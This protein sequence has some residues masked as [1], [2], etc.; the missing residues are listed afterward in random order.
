MWD[1][2]DWVDFY[3]STWNQ[4]APLKVALWAI[5]GWI[6]LLVGL[7]LYMGRERHFW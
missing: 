1:F 2:W 3:F 4:R 7:T 6:A 5:A